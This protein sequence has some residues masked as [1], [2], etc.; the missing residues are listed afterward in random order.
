[1][2]TICSTSAGPSGADGT[3][4]GPL[5]PSEDLGGPQKGLLGPNRALLGPPVAQKGPDNRSKCVLTM[6]LTQ[7]GQWGAGGTKSDSP[8]PSE[9]LRGPQKGHSGPKRALL[10]APGVP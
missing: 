8:R 7:A 6:S 1:M 10:G 4:Y 2:V 3:K 5:G 9:D